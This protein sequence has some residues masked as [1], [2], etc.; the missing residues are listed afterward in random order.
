LGAEKEEIMRNATT[1]NLIVTG[2]LFVG[3]VLFLTNVG[4]AGT[5]TNDKGEVVAESG[6]NVEKGQAISFDEYGRLKSQTAGYFRG[7]TNKTYT[8]MFRDENGNKALLECTGEIAWDKQGKITKGEKSFLRI[9][10]AARNRQWYVITSTE[11]KDGVLTVT[12]ET[13]AYT[14]FSKAKVEGPTG[15]GKAKATVTP[16]K[17]WNGQASFVLSNFSPSFN[18]AGRISMDTRNYEVLQTKTE[19]AQQKNAPDKQ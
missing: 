15:R 8:L 4:N 5:Q 14:F 10:T 9:M 12:A 6:L 19:G 17:V 13:G 3:V 2:M 11:L 18:D 1:A 7:T 16:N